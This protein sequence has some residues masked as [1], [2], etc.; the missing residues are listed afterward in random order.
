MMGNKI[1]PFPSLICIAGITVCSSLLSKENKI[2]ALANL[3]CFQVKKN[4]W[5]GNKQ[6]FCS[7][8]KQRWQ[9]IAK[10]LIP[11]LKIPTLETPYI[12]TLKKK[13]RF[14]GPQVSGV[15]GSKEKIPQANGRCGKVHTHGDYPKSDIS[16]SEWFPEGQGGLYCGL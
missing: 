14:R 12:Y 10:N 6:L 4:A 7:T 13:I 2:S 15:N 5:E 3:G 11:V 9:K 16:T 8:T 1:Q